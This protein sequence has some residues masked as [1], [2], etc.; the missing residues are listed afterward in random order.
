M[1]TKKLSTILVLGDSHA[2]VFNHPIWTD[3]FPHHY[4]HV[5]SVA[6]ATVSGLTNPN[7]ATQAAPIFQA[8]LKAL[9]N[10]TLVCLLGEVDV[11]FV[12]WYQAEKYGYS[13]QEMVVLALKKYQSFLLDLRNHGKVICI[14]TPLPTIGDNNYWGDVSNKRKDVKATQRERTDLTLFFN[15]AMQIYCQS[16]CIDY[17]D[18][19]KDLLAPNRLIHSNFLNPNPQDHHYD[20][21][22]FATLLASKLIHLI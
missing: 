9:T 19:D 14:S 8:H 4:F 12:I 18:C 22:K 7:S 17:V 13:I 3:L 16:N 1:S 10:Q 20:A 6:G 15:T 11:G 5:V 2:E 21:T